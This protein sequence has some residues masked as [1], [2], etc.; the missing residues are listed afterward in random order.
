MVRNALNR[1]GS[2]PYKLI[3]LEKEICN[4]HTVNILIIKQSMYVLVAKIDRLEEKDGEITI[5][6]L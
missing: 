6:G 4:H 3:A 1:P 5:V 2:H